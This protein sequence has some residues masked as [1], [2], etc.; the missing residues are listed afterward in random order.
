MFNFK[1]NRKN[2]KIITLVL[3]ILLSL[4]MGCQQHVEIKKLSA[5]TNQSNINPTPCEGIYL[6]KIVCLSELTN[7][8]S[9]DILVKPNHNWLPATSYVEGGS[10]FGH[11]VI[12]IQ[13]AT[14]PT[15]DSVLRQAVIFESQARN[16]PDE[17]QLRKVHAFVPGDD[18][19]YANTTFNNNQK[20]YRYRLRMKLTQTQKDSIIAFILRQDDHLSSWHAAKYYYTH[21]DTGTFKK[22]YFYCSLLIWQ[23][24]YYVLG[25][26]L[27]ANN[28]F[29]VYPSDIVNSPYFDDDSTV[30]N[31]R[32]RF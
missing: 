1:N 20:G 26:D 6:N 7:L 25:I 14:G 16:V 32:I 10:G 28:G 21:N 31:K 11:C 15:T 17:Y 29:M 23:A 2:M 30:K 13:G 19:R 5:N 8:E 24:F 27:D 4:F 22:Q 18:Y 9:C 12:V 3:L